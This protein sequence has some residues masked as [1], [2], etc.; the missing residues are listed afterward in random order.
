[1]DS[2]NKNDRKLV[3]MASEILL[4]S[5]RNIYMTRISMINRDHTISPRVREIV[6]ENKNLIHKRDETMKPYEFLNSTVNGPDSWLVDQQRDICRSE[7]KDIREK[8]GSGTRPKA[9]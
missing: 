5:D 8:S 1:M 3:S 6:S 2:K 4:K 7:E 9:N